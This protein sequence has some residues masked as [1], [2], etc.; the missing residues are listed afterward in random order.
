M[1]AVLADGPLGSAVQTALPAAT[2]YTT[3][4]LSMNFLR[5]ATADSGTLTAKGRLIHIGRSL[6]L[7]EV[8]VED[9]RGRLLAH[10]T[11]RCYVFPTISPA[12][13]PPMLEKLTPPEF[14]TP[15]PYLR[16]PPGA[17]LD[18]ETWRTKTGLE[19]MQG[20]ISLEAPPPPMYW[21]TGVHP[22]AVSEGSSTFAMPS[23]G[24]LCSPLG[25]VE[26]GFI[27]MLA[28][29]AMAGAVQSTVPA[30]TAYASVDLKVTFG[31]PVE[32]DGRDIT[33]TGTI[34]NRGRT[35][36]TARAEVTNADGKQVANAVGSAMILPDR[37]PSLGRAVA[38]AEEALPS[39]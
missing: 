23:S 11:S 31:R 29:A 24:W 37:S 39:E 4:E 7:S 26:G 34:V 10:G 21:L 38:P 8:F 30:G 20:H 32:P 16:D 18:E 1:L 17:V 2:P 6:A 25:R 28:D 9:A 15:D 33:A 12:P 22:V 3:A 14:P 36:A 5:P 27:A 35:L 19:I 13:P